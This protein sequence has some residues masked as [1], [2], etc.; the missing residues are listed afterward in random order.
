MP[1]LD[2]ALPALP[3]ART[4][5]PAT[6]RA[7]LVL[8]HAMERA[9][10]VVE[11][12]RP[13]RGLV[14]GLFQRR[15]YF[16]VEAS[17][18]AA[19]AERGHVVVVAFAG[20]VDGVP[21]GVHAVPLC[22]DDPRAGVWGLDLVRGACASTLT[23]TDARRL[24]A[25]ELTL[26]A[27]RG[28]EAHWTF[29]REAALHVARARFTALA[30]AL[31]PRVTRAALAVLDA[32]AAHPVSPGEAQLAAAM[33][34]LVASVDAGQRRVTRLRVELESA[35]SL[36]ERDQLTGLHNRHYLAR[37][38]GGD[39]RPADL[40]TL[41]IDVDDLKVVNDTHGHGAGDAVLSAVAASLT[42]H[43]RPGDVVLRWGGDEFLVLA[44]DLADQHGLTL[45]ERLAQAV[46][47]TRPAAPWDHL[48][49]S[50]SIGVCGIRRT[51]LPLDRLDQALV[52]VKRS[53]KGRAGL[54]PALDP[55]V[56]PAPRL[57]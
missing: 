4:T 24:V 45:G 38:L 57:A 3:P 44:P 36:A 32:T 46:R 9:F 10:G 11:G 50:V 39:D 20:P 13:A 28:F 42:T 35:Q 17:R 2:T 51:P 14:I 12:D 49:V 52:L 31:P 29:R 41:L 1:L 33:D 55:E 30:P 23:A 7:L 48:P 6:K 37:Y 40:M 21:S 15:E 27:S 26:E 47:T 19:L 56:V 18:Y 22:A 5:A 53:G 43:C 16:D 8:S 25:G 34:H 54:A